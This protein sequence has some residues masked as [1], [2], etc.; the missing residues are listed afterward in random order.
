[1]YCLLAFRRSWAFVRRVRL[2]PAA[3]EF[4][5]Y[6]KGRSGVCQGL[7]I[8]S[9]LPLKFVTTLTSVS[10]KGEDQ[11]PP[12]ME[13]ILL[14]DR[15]LSAIREQNSS[16][17][18]EC[19]SRVAAAGG[20]LVNLRLRQLLTM[21]VEMGLVIDAS[22][23]LLSTTSGLELR[24]NDLAVIA[25]FLCVTDACLSCGHLRRAWTHFEHA[26]TSGV[27]L[28]VLLC[29]EL[30]SKLFVAGL[31][32]EEEKGEMGAWKVLDYTRQMGM[33]HT[34][35]VCNT[36]LYCATELKDLGF[37]LRMLTYMKDLGLE[38]KSDVCFRLF[39][40]VCLKLELA[41]VEASPQEVEKM[42][43]DVAGAT[44]VKGGDNGSS[45]MARGELLELERILEGCMKL[46][47]EEGAINFAMEKLPLLDEDDDIEDESGVQWVQVTVV[48]PKKTGSVDSLNMG[49]REDEVEVRD[50]PD[51]YYDDP[52][53]A[54]GLDCSEVCIV[55]E[56]LRDEGESDDDDDRD[57]G[58]GVPGSPEEHGDVAMGPVVDPAGSADGD[59]PAVSATM[60]VGTNSGVNDGA[61]RHSSLASGGRI[62]D[63]AFDRVPFHANKEVTNPMVAGGGANLVKAPQKEVEQEDQF[64]HQRPEEGCNWKMVCDGHLFDGDL[65]SEL[66][67]LHPLWGLGKL[68]AGRLLVDRLV[69][70]EE[71]CLNAGV[72]GGGG[73]D[74][75]ECR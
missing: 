71:D 2:R 24:S 44:D 30:A 22:D 9:G 38:P 59:M 62:Q 70:P 25:A 31:E 13:D 18:V 63:R 35:E 3:G 11:S 69:D 39:H 74:P 75:Q 36:A 66:Q 15:F 48:G 53:E 58:V 33:V 41:D 40:A 61:D 27:L 64:M 45:D 5:N 8:S 49:E 67:V 21:L 60:A 68:K 55:E 7:K 20:P 51:G 23:L 17:A 43:E 37:A 1:M 52:E 34:S 72:Q 46:E 54:D 57:D 10:D 56:D 42:G 73:E 16:K 32:G 50:A 19:F 14:H 6:G 65:L 4:L 28:D 29:E 12:G 47:P 26:A